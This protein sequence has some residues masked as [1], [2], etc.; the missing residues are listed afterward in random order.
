MTV[1]ENIRR[2]R[3]ERKLTQKR[4]GELVGASEAYIRAYESGRR[5]PK[6][7]SLEAIARALAVNVEVLNNSDFDGVKAMHRLFQVFRQYNGHLFECKDDEGNDA[8]GI[9]F[10]TLTL[11]RSWFRR[12]EKYIKEVEECNEI[13]DVKQ[14]GEALLKAEADFNM[15]MDI[16]PGS[17]P[18]PEDLQMQK[19]HDD[20]MDKIGLNPKNEK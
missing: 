17:E 16:Y 8:V 15:W 10:G 1:G 7:K 2:I 9:S 13:K 18:C 19:T 20:F 11:M 3:Q 12:Y 14:R 6:P 5:N 4:L